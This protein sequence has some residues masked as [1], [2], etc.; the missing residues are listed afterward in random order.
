MPDHLRFLSLW[1]RL[2]EDGEM[3][4][5]ILPTRD[6]LYAS[7]K[8]QIERLL[9]SRCPGGF[10][11]HP[12]VRRSVMNYGL[13][14]LAGMGSRPLDRKRL[15]RDVETAIEAFEPRVEAVKVAVDDRV[16]TTAGAILHLTITGRIK[17]WPEPLPLDL[18][19][20][21]DIGTGQVTLVQRRGQGG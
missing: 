14:D 3:A 9:N 20:R 11:R 21:I 15:I 19:S 17:A 7:V 2:A 5:G 18:G 16:R 12:H 13:P 8:A 1:E 6:S 10:D 4:T